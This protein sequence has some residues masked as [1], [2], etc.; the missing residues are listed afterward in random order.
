[1]PVQSPR[2][3]LFDLDG[4]LIDTAPDMTAALNE[5]LI[6]E[7]S[8]PLQFAQARPFVSHGATALV[9]LGFPQ[10][11]EEKFAALRKRFLQIYSTL[12]AGNTRMFDGLDAALGALESAGIVWGIVTNKP[13]WLAAPLLDHLGLSHRA[14][15]IV[16]GDT[17]AQRKPHPAQLL[18]A[19]Q[20]LGF[21]PDEC[22][23]IGD[24]ERDVLAARAAGMPV[25]VALFGYIP[26]EEQPRSWPATG[27]LTE[28]QDLV[29]LLESLSRE[30]ARAPRG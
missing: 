5:L 6:E 7:G 22:I 13:G 9:R 20:K 19:A 3:V 11:P 24:A 23:Y 29:S 25:F 14:G 28:A 16:S 8:A 1:V 17:L 12:L 30:A 21:Q 27:W 18:H 4:T 10:V 26:E 15:V 2:A